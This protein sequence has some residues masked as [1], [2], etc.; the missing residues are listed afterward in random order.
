MLLRFAET[1]RGS[2]DRQDGARQLFQFSIRARSGFIAF[3]LG[4]PCD[5]EGHALLEGTG[6][7]LPLTGTLHVGLPLRRRLDYDLSF[8]GPDGDLYRYIGR[9]NVR[10]LHFFLTMSRLRGTLYRNGEP[11]GPAELWFSYRGLPA[12]LLSFLPCSPRGA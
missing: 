10:Y 4:D 2:V 3:V 9:K 1:M 12:F 7:S 5:V 6:D 8:K 11:V